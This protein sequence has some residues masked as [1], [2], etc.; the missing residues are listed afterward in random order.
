M[1]RGADIKV[2]W[3]EPSGQFRKQIGKQVGRNGQPSPKVHY[4]G[5]D[6]RTAKRRALALVAEWESL[7]EQGHVVWPQMRASNKRDDDRDAIRMVNASKLTVGDAIELYREDVRRRCELGLVSASYRNTVSFQ[8][9]WLHRSISGMTLLSNVSPQQIRQAVEFFVARPKRSPQRLRTSENRQMSIRVARDLVKQLKAV[10][11][12]VEDE[13]PGTGYV[14]PPGFEKLFKI[15]W[16]KLRTV[17]EEEL[18]ALQAINGEVKT[19][20]IDELAAIW[21]AAPERVRLYMLLALNFGWT[22]KE[23]SDAKTFN[24]DLRADEPFAFKSRSKTDVMARWVVWPETA[25]AL[26]A[27]KAPMNPEKRW[28][29]NQKGLPLVRVGDYRRDAVYEAW[30]RTLAKTDEEQ[31]RR[32]GFRFLRKT[33]GNWIK[34][35]SGLEASEMFLS[36]G[37]PGGEMNRFYA[38]RRWDVMWESLRAFRQALSFLDEDDRG[39]A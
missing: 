24:F 22:S 37:E 35:Q 27:N 28:L 14:R 16:R 18:H 7:K 33:A 4:L 15:N 2:T 13:L 39:T 10:F 32:L 31:V 23:I 8:L 36:H 20:G 6:E 5:P 3:H 25:L 29:L 34:Q 19:F 1:A 17:E 9:D 26:N 21:A 38:N 11:R 12:Y 30:K